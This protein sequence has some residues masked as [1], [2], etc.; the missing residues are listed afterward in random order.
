VVWV[1][2]QRLRRMYVLGVASLPGDQVFNVLQGVRLVV[3]A[4]HVMSQLLTS[5]PPDHRD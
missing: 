2:R 3:Q 5:F 1:Y 4:R